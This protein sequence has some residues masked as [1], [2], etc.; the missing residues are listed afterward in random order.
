M[1][2]ATSVPISLHIKTLNNIGPLMD[3][4]ASYHCMMLNKVMVIRLIDKFALLKI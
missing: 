1:S 2:Q 4:S 3:A